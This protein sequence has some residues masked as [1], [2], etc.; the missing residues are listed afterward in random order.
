MASA[1]DVRRKRG[2]SH[3]ESSFES[4]QALK[5]PSKD[6]K[7]DLESLFTVDT[8]GSTAQLLFFFVAERSFE[9]LSQAPEPLESLL[10]LAFQ[11]SRREMAKR[12]I[13]PEKKEKLGLTG[14]EEAK[15]ERVVERL[16][17]R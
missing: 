11:R 6:S 15:V 4:L 17:N 7:D 3:S 1:C 9:G 5:G 10:A 16:A 8:K 14:S 2:R 12:K 13:F